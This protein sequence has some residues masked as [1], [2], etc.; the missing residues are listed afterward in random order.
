MILPPDTLGTLTRMDASFP[1]S[2]KLLNP[3]NSKSTHCGVSVFVAERGNC[4]I[5]D[6]MMVNLELVQGSRITLESVTLPKGEF[7]L[8]EPQS[9]DFLDITDPKAVLENTLSKFQYIST[10]DIIP[11]H[12][13]EKTYEVKI[14]EARPA[15]AIS[16]IDS[17]L[18]VDFSKPVGYVEPTSTVPKKVEGTGPEFLPF[19]GK[20]QRLDDKPLTADQERIIDQSV[21]IIRGLPDT[22][23]KFGSI[24]FMREERPKEI[25]S[26]AQK[27]VQAFSGPGTSLGGNPTMPDSIPTN[28]DG[29]KSVL[30]GSGRKKVKLSPQDESL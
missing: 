8:L 10:G 22:D 26:E 14:L 17:D 1:L 25:P 7:A 9:V 18:V 23:F 15:S 3:T 19:A 12:Y 30:T 13:N 27:S 4:Y 2:F 20:G 11:I 28:G 6:W 24:T 16:I 21:K 5:P 29:S